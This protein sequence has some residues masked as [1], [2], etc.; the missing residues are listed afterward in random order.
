MIAA[1]VAIALGVAASAAARMPL[2]WRSCGA[3]NARYPHGL[4]RVGAHDVTKGDT[5]PVTNFKRSNALYRTAI[6]YNRG[7]D[8]DHDGVACERLSS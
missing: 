4:G 6:G 3:V 5:D 7:L 1:L 8:R 2:Q